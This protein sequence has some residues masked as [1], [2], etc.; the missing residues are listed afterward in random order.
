MD[1]GQGWL[2]HGW[3]TRTWEVK[4]LE[5]SA[6]WRQPKLSPKSENSTDPL[7]HWPGWV[8][9]DAI[10]SKKNISCF[11][12]FI[13]LCG[14]YLTWISLVSFIPWNGKWRKPITRCT[15]GSFSAAGAYSPGVF[16]IKHSCYPIAGTCYVACMFLYSSSLYV[17]FRNF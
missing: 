5:T 3:L 7:T 6:T 17:A 8:L 10:A 12:I 16:H 2:D 15:T 14:K 13:Y 1:G 4:L 9:G 11:F